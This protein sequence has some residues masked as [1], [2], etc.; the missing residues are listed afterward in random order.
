MDTG[1]CFIE[2]G[3]QHVHGGKALAD[4]CVKK[5]GKSRLSSALEA[6]L[7]KTHKAIESWRHG[8]CH[9]EAKRPDEILNGPETCRAEAYRYTPTF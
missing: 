2:A 3:W 6:V 7:Y 9:C 8:N 4:T 5:T 1:E